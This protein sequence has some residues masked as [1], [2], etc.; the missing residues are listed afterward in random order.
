MQEPGLMT[1]DHIRGTGIAALAAIV[2]ACVPTERGI[3]Q[4]TVAASQTNAQASEQLQPLTV[5]FIGDQGL[6]RK[7]RAVLQLIVAEGADLVLHQGDLDYR[8]DPAAWDALITEVLGADFPV[9]ASVGNHDKRRWYGPNGYQAKLQ[10][11]LDRIGDATCSGDLGVQSACTFRGLFFILSG[12][13]TIPDEPDHP[14]HVAYLRDQLA[15]TDAIWRICSWH[16]NQRLMQVGGK[17]SQVGWEPYEAC[18]EGGAI[19][20]TAH[21]HSYS[22]THLMDDFETQSIASTSKTLVIEEGKSFVFVSGLGGHSIRPQR[23][24]GPWWASVYTRAQDADAGA[25]F[26]DFFQHGEPNRASCHFR[27]IDGKV[28]D[29]FELI[30]AVKVS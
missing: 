18:R 5:A 28:P 11:R 2:F 4:A 19:V 25:L 20:A 23:R 17:P 30:S 24:D 27:D 14:E 7:A 15:Q 3:G 6:G 29:R 8:N 12:A 13:G 21:E 22:R 1:K 10:A 26:C 16:K 9:F